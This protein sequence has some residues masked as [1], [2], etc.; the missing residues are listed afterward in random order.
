MIINKNESIE[1]K[2]YARDQLSLNNCYQN[3]MMHTL[4]NNFM[5]LVSERMMNIAQQA[6]QQKF[7]MIK[8]DVFPSI[9]ELN[10]VI[11]HK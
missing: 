7:K 11:Q 6:T 8:D 3:G 10:Y 9:S 5:V 1:L 4:T 2:N